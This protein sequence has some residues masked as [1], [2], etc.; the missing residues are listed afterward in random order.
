MATLTD[1]VNVNINEQLSIQVV[2]V[3]VYVESEIDCK[4]EVENN[5][6]TKEISMEEK[7]RLFYEKRLESIT[8]CLK[9][10]QTN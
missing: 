3:V 1:Y 8:K 4:D 2:N 10:L 7:R 6:D 9:F 5:I